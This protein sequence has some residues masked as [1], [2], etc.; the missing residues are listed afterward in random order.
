VRGLYSLNS[1]S[2]HERI[3]GVLPLETEVLLSRMCRGPS[4]RACRDEASERPA[5]D[6]HHSELLC[7]RMAEALTIV[8]QCCWMNWKDDKRSYFAS[9]NTNGPRDCSIATAI[10]CPPNRSLSSAAQ[11][12]TSSG[13]CQCFLLH[14]PMIQ[15]PEAALGMSLVRPIDCNICTEVCF[16]SPLSPLNFSTRLC[17]RESLIVESS[18][19]IGVVP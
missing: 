2:S 6:R 17:L 5:G 16:H 1:S 19:W 11:T 12:S 14:A 13:V 3:C 18:C 8:C 7:L 4:G 9:M 10:G 15:V